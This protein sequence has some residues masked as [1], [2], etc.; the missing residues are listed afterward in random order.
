LHDWLEAWAE[1]TSSISWNKQ[2]TLNK[3]KHVAWVDGKEVAHGRPFIRGLRRRRVKQT[4]IMAE[5]QK[6]K[7]RQ[8]LGEATS[9]TLSVDESKRRKL[10]RFKCDSKEPPFWRSGVLGIIGKHIRKAIGDVLDSSEDHA[11]ESV[12]LLEAFLNH[13]CT[14]LAKEAVVDAELKAHIL[15]H[16][17][18]LAADGASSER[19]ALFAAMERLF[20]NVVLVI[21][22]PAHAIRI[23]VSKPLHADELFGEVWHELFDKRH[24][25]VPDIQ[26]SEKWKE[27]LVR[28]EEKVL[29]LAD[30]SQP[31][32]VVLQHLSFA[33]Q[34]FDSAADPKAKLALMLLPVCTLLAHIASDAR[35][36][37]DERSRAEGLLTK[38]TGKFALALAL[39]ADWGI[40]TQAFLRL[41]DRRGHDIARSVCEV[42]DFIEVIDVIFAQ[43][44]VFTSPGQPLERP[45]KNHQP[46]AISDKVVHGRSRIAAA[47][48]TKYTEK[49]IRQRCVFHCGG[50]QV[51][52]WG[53]CHEDALRELTG[54]MQN[55]A[56]VT[57]DRLKAEYPKTNIRGSLSCFDL[58]RVSKAF[59]SGGDVATRDALLAGVQK[60]AGRVGVDPCGA[61]RAYQEWAPVAL[62]SVGE[63][64]PLAPAL[65]QSGNPGVW[66]SLL[67][68]DTRGQILHQARHTFAP[69]ESVIR[70]YI[71]IED[72]ECENERDI[73]DIRDE[74]L[75]HSGGGFD[76]SSLEDILVLKCGPKCKDDVVKTLPD[77]R[78]ELTE[79]SESSALLWLRYVSLCVCVCVVVRATAWSVGWIRVWVD[80]PPV[81]F[82]GP[83]GA[84]PDV[85]V[86]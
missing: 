12:R 53:R 80:G 15:E 52:A 83:A 20:K 29:R 23:A 17:R 27:L 73:G 42:E 25:L 50:R 85:K 9:I 51:V 14:P 39:S 65:K 56:L 11:I 84:P 6:R 46:L 30:G 58:R 43:G 75:E 36:K 68:G 3:K 76:D 24:A 7:H 60:L 37:V 26:H 2:E 78:L 13:A 64:Q 45:P 10:I 66:S 47:F 21:R 74:V 28:I 5:T 1:T 63:G 81:V 22:D 31:L 18:V 33:K 32:A 16:V 69:L 19:R 44:H 57:I 62:T 35:L 71:S 59:K 86:G 67:D 72:G 41:F 54:R 48:I 38:M 4:K 77:G 8:W 34:R 49:T 40:V 55:V 79:F 70:F 82:W 61:V